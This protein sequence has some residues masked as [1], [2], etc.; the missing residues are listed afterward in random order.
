MSFLLMKLA[1]SSAACSRRD[2]HRDSLGK[3]KLFLQQRRVSA[4]S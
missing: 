4:D 1:A 2:S 3:A